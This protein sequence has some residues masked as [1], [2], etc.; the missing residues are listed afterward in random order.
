MNE[1]E[2]YACISGNIKQVIELDLPI[3]KQ[4]FVEGLNSGKY[5]T[6]IGHGDIHGKV[7]ELH[8]VHGIREIG[9]VVEQEALDDVEINQFELCGSEQ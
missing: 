5:A 1:I 4:E 9:R 7:I 8:P 6:T 2:I 3:T